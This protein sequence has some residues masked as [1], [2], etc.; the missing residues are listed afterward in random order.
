MASTRI[1][2]IPPD[3]NSP[4]ESGSGSWPGTARRRWARRMQDLARGEP[5][6]DEV[7]ALKRR[8]EEGR[9]PRVERGG[10]VL[11]VGGLHLPGGW[12]GDRPLG[13]VVSERRPEVERDALPAGGGWREDDPRG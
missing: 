11:P 4:P 6:H 2:I 7:V 5:R 13:R 8:R 10:D 12:P 3:V 9:P 1:R